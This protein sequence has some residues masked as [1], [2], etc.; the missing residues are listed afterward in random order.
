[1]VYSTIEELRA[2]AKRVKSLVD[3]ECQVRAA[4]ADSRPFERAKWLRKYRQAVEAQEALGRLLDYVAS[5]KPEERLEAMPVQ[6][7]IKIE[8]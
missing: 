6:M 1:M 5:L 3:G 2:D 4:L 7:K 8:E